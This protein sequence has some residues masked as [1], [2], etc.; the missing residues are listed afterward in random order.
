MM[1]TM[2]SSGRVSYLDREPLCDLEGAEGKAWTLR[3]GLGLPQAGLR[4]DF[5]EV[6]LTVSVTC[7]DGECA[8]SETV[9]YEGKGSQWIDEL[10]RC[11]DPAIDAQV[12]LTLDVFTKCL[13]IAG[14]DRNEAATIRSRV[15]ASD[16]LS[17]SPAYLGDWET[18]S[19]SERHRTLCAVME[20]DDPLT[21]AL[22]D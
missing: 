2:M 15:T 16:G 20:V 10:V 18:Q 12:S 1:R 5:Q 13:M 7:E 22:G 4:H 3:L 21:P 8:V 9:T 19:D 14:Y 6:P 11:S 17:V